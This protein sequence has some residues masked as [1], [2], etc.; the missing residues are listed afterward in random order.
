MKK[1]VRSIS[2]PAN[3]VFISHQRMQNLAEPTYFKINKHVVLKG[4]KSEYRL[5]IG[6]PICLLFCIQ[7]TQ[8]L[9]GIILQCGKQL[10]LLQAI[11]ILIP[12]L[13]RQAGRKQISFLSLSVKF[14]PI[15]YYLSPVVID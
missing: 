15:I 8:R 6:L 7:W 4:E 10:Y 3:S 12:V 14:L 9:R 2:T 13:M 1:K 5:G 11:L